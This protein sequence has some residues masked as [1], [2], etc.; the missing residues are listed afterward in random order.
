MTKRDAGSARISRRKVIGLLGVGAGLGLVGGFGERRGVA[1]AGQA[2]AGAA[3]SLAIPEGAIVRT[4][5]QDLPP[6]RLGT[7]AALMHEHLSAGGN[8]DVLVDELRAAGQ[9][10]LSCIVDAATGRREGVALDRLKT[11]STRSGVNSN[12]TF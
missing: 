8:V 10:G 6:D 7:G 1:A 9:E 3:Q 4:I 12:D 11:I 5:L 2:T